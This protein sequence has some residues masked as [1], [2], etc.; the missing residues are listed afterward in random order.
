MT[1]PLLRQLVTCA[2]ALQGAFILA[3]EQGHDEVASE[4]RLA[5]LKVNAAIYAATHDG[6]GR[7]VES[8][9]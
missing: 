3:R 6:E 4:I 7:V 1:P 2:N 8:A 9:P 5:Q